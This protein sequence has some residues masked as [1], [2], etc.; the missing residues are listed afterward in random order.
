M[1]TL[2]DSPARSRAGFTL[3]EVMVVAA[4]V[5]LLSAIAIPNMAKSRDTA[6]AAR[7]AHDIRL[8]M[9]AFTAYSFER[10]TYPPDRQ[11]GEVP[12]GMEDYL[13][14]IQW[15]RETS[16]G[17]QWDWDYQVF[18][19]KAG[20]SVFQPIVGRP[21]LELVDQLMDNG[22]LAS[23]GFRERANGYIGFIE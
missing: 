3:V 10:G 13:R 11:P 8:A 22:D 21:V 1:K 16:L 17:G 9:D 12:P 23:G 6:A 14:P 7:F 5:G 18:G 19:V 4:V 2:T 20:V 15:T